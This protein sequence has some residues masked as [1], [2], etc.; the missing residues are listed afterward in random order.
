MTRYL[1]RILVLNL[2]LG[3]IAALVS[4]WLKEPALVIALSHLSLVALLLAPLALKRPVFGLDP[5]LLVSVYLIVG[6]VIPSYLLVVHESDRLR[7]ILNGLTAPALVEGGFWYLT[8]TF[9]IG[10]GYAACK[11]RI[12]VEDY[13][14]RD[15]IISARGVQVATI[16]GVG[17]AVLA[18]ALF[19]SRTGGLNALSAKRSV[20]IATASG[21]VHGSG[22]YYRM[23]GDL[24]LFILL[25]SCSF[26]LR[27]EKRLPLTSILLLTFAASI[28]PFLA[29]SREAILYIFLGLLI[30]LGAFQKLSVRRVVLVLTIASL[31]FVAMTG[32]RSQTQG[33]AEAFQIPN[34]LIALGES[35]NGLSLIGTTHILQGVPESLPYQYGA[36]YLTWLTA[37]VP[38]QW[39]PEKPDVSLGKR[40]RAEILGQPVIRSG[41]PPSVLAEGWMNFGP[42]GF[43]LGAFCFGYSLRLLSTSFL[44]V[45]KKNVLLPPA[46][47]ATTLGLTGMVNAAFSQVVVRILTDLTLIALA[48][49]LILLASRKNYPVVTPSRPRPGVFVHK[50][51]CRIT[52]RLIDARL[53]HAAPTAPWTGMR[54]K[55]PK[56]FTTSALNVRTPKSFWRPET[57]RNAD[58]GTLSAAQ[59]WANARNRSTSLPWAKSGPNK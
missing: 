33:N 4:P 15:T 16:I 17:I 1:W 36:T 6:A 9:L 13:V 45:L 18:T 21:T 56:T 52:S 34:A 57:I 43:V 48:F 30:V 8:G 7:F 31:S 25:I 44:P 10:C 42:L 20:M 37:P 23:L 38:R 3:A 26:W 12:Q 51:N 2:A 22:A 29:S 46:Y 24:S 50:D 27:R 28:I 41:R 35:G 58:S 54:I 53:A 39:W 47:V 40:I 55:L 32:L 5:L 59:T 14:P 19:V 49:G 11:K